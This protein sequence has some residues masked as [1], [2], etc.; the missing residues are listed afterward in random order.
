MVCHKKQCVLREISYFL[1]QSVFLKINQNGP[2]DFFLLDFLSLCFRVPH[3][4][5]F[6]GVPQTGTFEQILTL[7]L[8]P[9]K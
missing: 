4:N 1:G 5:F 6:F 3:K 9:P 8:E 7:Q 2:I